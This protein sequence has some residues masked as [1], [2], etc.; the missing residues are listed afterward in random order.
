MQNN[1]SQPTATTCADCSTRRKLI[2]NVV[3][4]VGALALV[5]YMPAYAGAKPIY[6]KG[7]ANLALGGYDP[8]SYFNTNAPKKGDANYTTQYKGA[9]WN[10]IS[11]ENLDAF[12][13]TPE[14]Y[15][16]QYGGYC[17]YSVSI[18]KLVK[19]DPTLWAIVDD[20]LYVNYN[21]NVHKRWM[22][23]TAVM[24]ERGDAQWPSIVG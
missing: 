15:E 19:G 7:R 12:L 3:Q 4:T 8:V 17:A 22:A 5:Q 23:R 24:I 13:S 10:F 2:K 21:R 9:N 6:T 14:T 1:N 16:P 11:Q 18:G 20:R